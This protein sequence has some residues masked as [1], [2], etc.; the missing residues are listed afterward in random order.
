MYFR[1]RSTYKFRKK[2]LLNP[3]TNGLT[4]LSTSRK[5]R[6]G[7]IF[8]PSTTVVT[9]VYGLLSY[10]FRR[11]IFSWRLLVLPGDSLSGLVSKTINRY[12]FTPYSW[13]TGLPLPFVRI[14]CVE[15]PDRPRSSGSRLRT[16]TVLGKVE[17]GRKIPVTVETTRY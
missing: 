15:G 6:L 16:K 1:I 8:I 4:H 9:P 3:C 17:D 7:Y 13:F 14:S 5:R 12:C 10:P 2:I 11:T